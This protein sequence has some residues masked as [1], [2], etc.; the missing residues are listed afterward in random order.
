MC[1]TR[2]IVLTGLSAAV[3][4]L[5][6][7]KCSPVAG[8]ATETENITAML[9]N[10]DGTPAAQ[11]KVCFYRHNDDPRN[12]HAV[13]STYTDNNGNYKKELDTGTYN[14]L[15]T[16]GTNATFQD[17]IIVIDG[18]TTRPPQDTLRSLGSISG[19]IELQGT[20][21]PRTVFIL[22]MGS[23][24]FT[25]P[26]DLLGNFTATNIAKGRY[27]VTLLTT[28]DNYDV[29]DTSFMITAGLD[30]VIP[31]PIVMKYTGIPVPKGLR[32]VYDSMMQIV[33]LIWDKP[34]T[35]IVVQGYNI[36]RKHQDSAI[37][38]L[39]GDWRDTVYHDSTAMQDIAYEYRVTAIDT[40][41][42]EGTRSGAVGI[43]VTSAFAFVKDIQLDSIG[44]N[45]S[46]FVIGPDTSFYVAFSRS[47]GVFNK[48][49]Q[50]I[51]I[52]G[53]GKTGNHDIY[54]FAIDSKEFVYIAC[55]YIRKF[56]TTGDSV[57]LWRIDYPGQ[58]LIDAQDNIFMTHGGGARD[59]ITKFD[60][61]G[62][63][64]AGDT[65][66]SSTGSMAMDYNGRI[67]MQDCNSYPCRLLVYDN[68]LAS[69]SY[70]SFSCSGDLQAIDSS[71]N[72]YSRNGEYVN[73][74]NNIG[75]PIGRWKA[76]NPDGIPFQRLLLSG[77]RI[78]I[79]GETGGGKIRVFSNPF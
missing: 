61:T 18:D 15:A 44:N 76:T 20:D 57:A 60:T 21:D 39:R 29:M 62:N 69:K 65:I 70:T 33:T 63:I 30:S 27:P 32:I 13:D 35:G 6:C 11:A 19:K 26:T 56:N 71:G 47:V 41:T 1:R 48:T 66:G 78:Y 45:P 58:I 59:S 2:R 77:G 73:V 8:T 64:L 38:L 54:D 17:S 74:Y 40:N 3:A 5:F 46:S 53:A 34:T 37:T 36:Y 49:G 24:T 10:P 9:Y 16:L 7:V 23:N 12:N 55:G 14:I 22:L 75:A 51:K 68:N 28:L 52:I 4:V 72:F 25:R 67:F 31:Q 43:T 42:M 50:N 79:L